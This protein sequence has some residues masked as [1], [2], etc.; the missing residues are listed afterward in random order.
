MGDLLSEIQAEFDRIIELYIVDEGASNVGLYTGIA[1]ECLLMAQCYLGNG[2]EVYL[3]KCHYYLDQIISFIENESEV[4]SSFSSGM[5]GCGWVIQF[6]A[7]HGLI[8]PDID[9]ML[10]DID[11]TLFLRM[12]TLMSEDIFDP[13]NGAI[14]IGKYFIK[15]KKFDKAAWL[16]HQ[17]DSL[18]IDTATGYKWVKKRFVDSFLSYDLGLAHGSAGIIHFFSLCHNHGIEVEKCKGIIKGAIS[19]LMNNVQDFSVYGCFFPSIIPVDESIKKE[20]DFSFSRLAWCYGD[21]TILYTLYQQAIKFKDF[22]LEK[23]CIDSLIKTTSRTEYEQTHIVDAGFCHGSCGIAYIYY[24]LYLINGNSIFLETS[25]LWIKKTLAYRV[26]GSGLESYQFLIGNFET[27]IF[28]SFRPLLE[29][30]AGVAIV[31]QSFLNAYSQ[32]WDE[33]MML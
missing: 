10:F 14:G 24:K 7:D 5:A 27:R 28:Q 17:I 9:E 1:G 21:L 11:E 4:I 31:Y 33:C 29:G 22:E 30:L 20:K 32:E 6:L 18:K 15:R 25:H 12:Q 16:V 2:D 19:Y 3:E 13:I 8:D 26:S 23:F